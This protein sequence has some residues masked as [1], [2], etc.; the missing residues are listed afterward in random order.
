[1]LIPGEEGAKDVPGNLGIL[2]K[3]PDGV[4]VP[5]LPE[6]NVDTKTVSVGKDSIAKLRPDTVKHLELIIG[7]L[8]IHLP[9]ILVGAGYEKIV[10]GCNADKAP[11]FE[12]LLQELQIIEPDLFFVPESDRLWLNIGS[13]AK[14][15]VR[16]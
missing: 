12:K 13:L 15:D 11:R 9:N 5:L 4:G 7:F 6:R 8:E 2:F 16:F 3:T 10:M 1:M 14:P